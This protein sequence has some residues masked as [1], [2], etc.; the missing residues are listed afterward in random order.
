MHK[1][2]FM[3]LTLFSLI[4]T[5]QAAMAEQPLAQHFGEYDSCYARQYSAEHLASHPNQTVAQIEFGHFPTRYKEWAYDPE[6]GS[7]PFIVQVTFRDSDKIYNDFGECRPQADGLRCQI[8]C[9]GGGFTLTHKDTDSIL[10][11]TRDGNGFTVTGCGDEDFRQ[12]STKTDDKVFLLHRLPAA[13]C[14]YPQ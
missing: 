8:E 1:I 5:G 14:K 4:L 11:H 10:L 12:I 2:L 9:D 13:Q 3:I 7:I 6:E